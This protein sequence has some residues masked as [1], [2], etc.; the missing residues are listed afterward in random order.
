MSIILG[1]ILVLLLFIFSVAA[2]GISSYHDHSIKSLWSNGW[3]TRLDALFIAAG[4]LLTV[5]NLIT[6]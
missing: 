4:L 6:L 5:K 3:G 1:I 2:Y